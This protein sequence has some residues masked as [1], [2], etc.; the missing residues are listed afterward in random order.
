VINQELSLIV[1]SALYFLIFS[2]KAARSQ[3]NIKKPLRPTPAMRARR[4]VCVWQYLF[5]LDLA[6]IFSLPCDMP[7]FY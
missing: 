4:R 2:R 7:S 5:N 6:S 1:M 3:S